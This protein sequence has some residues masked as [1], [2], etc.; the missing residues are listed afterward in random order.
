MKNFLPVLGL[1]LGITSAR[2]DV[3]V[4]VRDA[5]GLASVEYE[6]TAAELIRAFALDVRVDRGQVVAVGDYFRGDCKPGS[7]GYGIFPA[8]LRNL[9]LIQNATNINWS[10]SGYSPLAM[11]ADD[12]AGTLPGLNSSGVTLEFGALWDP[13]D[14]AAWPG[15]SGRL[16]TLTLSQ[17]ARVSV[18]PNS[19]RGGIISAITGT[20]VTAQFIGAMVGPAITSTTLTNGVLNLLF[21]GGALESAPALSGPWTPVS[22]LSGLYTETIGT[23]RARFYRVQGQ[24]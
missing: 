22:N 11:V 23:N 16:C 2:A 6:C 14:P 19:T 17:P 3:R 9:A 10:A 15:T 1:V 20:A 18:A 7:T 12:P 24:P 8:S 21:Q 4:F 5:N 13:S